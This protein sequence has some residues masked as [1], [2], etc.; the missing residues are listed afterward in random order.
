VAKNV[1]AAGLADAARSGSLRD[2]DA[3]P[4]ASNV[5]ILA[6]ASSPME[7]IAEL[8]LENFD[9]VPAPSF[10]DLELRRPFYRKIAA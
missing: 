7:K 10:A 2:R 6:R 1:V 5:E 4:S 9:C 3:N 8:V